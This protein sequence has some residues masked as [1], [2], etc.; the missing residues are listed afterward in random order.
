VYAAVKAAGLKP[1][2]VDIAKDTLNFSSTALETAL[3]TE[4]AIKAAIVQNT[5]GMSAAIDGISRLCQQYGI[6]IVED[7]AHSAGLTYSSGQ[8]AGTVGIA[9]AL[10]FSQD[11]MIDAVSGGAALLFQPKAFEPDYQ[12]VGGWQRLQAFWYPFNTFIVRK[13]HSFGVGKAWLKFLRATKLLPDQMAGDPREIRVLPNHQ[14]KW[15]AIARKD[16]PAA[17]RHRQKIADVYRQALP[18]EIQI[19]HQAGSVYIRFPLLVNNPRGLETYL[20]TQ[21]IHI[22]RPWYDAV[23]APGRYMLQTDYQTGQCPNAEYVAEHI[24]NLPTHIN[25]SEAQAQELAGKVHEWL[26]SQ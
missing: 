20:K 22:A 7:L 4:P 24:I 11:K 1:Y 23:I 8:A 9:A 19:P 14:A 5:L 12:S 17:I 25:I 15:A 21:N 16:L 18:A 13:T 26:K 2:M 3:K 10:S 6:S